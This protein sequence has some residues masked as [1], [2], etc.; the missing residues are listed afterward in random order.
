M[1]KTMLVQLKG[2]EQLNTVAARLQENYF[3]ARD[4]VKL[5]IA[6]AVVE[7]I[8]LMALVP[9]YWPLIGLNWLNT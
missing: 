4:L 8:L 1:Q 6:L 2:R 5:S 3:E 9:L 7:G